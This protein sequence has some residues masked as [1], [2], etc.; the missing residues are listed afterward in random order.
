VVVNDSFELLRIQ[1]TTTQME[2][3]AQM[4]INTCTALGEQNPIAMIHDVG[5]GGQ[6]NA[7]PE[8]E[9]IHFTKPQLSI[10]FL[11]FYQWSRTPDTEETSSSARWKA[12][13][14]V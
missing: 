10:T 11:T 6:T 12:W 8:R 5:D 4:V 9:F 14:K 7:L 2:R 3:R 13:I 1:L